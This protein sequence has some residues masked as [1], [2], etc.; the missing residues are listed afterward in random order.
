LNN[1]IDAIFGG[2]RI[3]IRLSAGRSWNRTFSRGVRL[4]I[5]DSGSGIA[6]EN[7]PRMFEPF[8]TTNKDVGTGLGLWICK[9]IVEKHHGSIRFKTWTIPGKSGTVFTV[10]LPGDAMAQSTDS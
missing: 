10:F 2:G 7:R 3:R 8:F 6:P 1:S 5:A 9:S 4:T